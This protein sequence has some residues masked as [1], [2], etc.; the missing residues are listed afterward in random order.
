MLY[1]LGQQEKTERPYIEMDTCMH[2]YMHDHEASHKMAIFSFN[3]WGPPGRM[4]AK[5]VGDGLRS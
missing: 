3:L 5:G 1:K 4:T 2:P